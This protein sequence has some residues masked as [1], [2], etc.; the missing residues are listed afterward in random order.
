MTTLSATRAKTLV[1]ARTESDAGDW[2]ARNTR[3]LEGAAANVVTD[4][5]DLEQHDLRPGDRIVYVPGFSFSANAR[6]ILAH[7]RTMA[8][9]T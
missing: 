3:R 2:L 6:G 4:A 1:I 7:L 5:I 8:V 9:S